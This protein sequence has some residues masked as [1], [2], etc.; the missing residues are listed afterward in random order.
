MQAQM[1]S[2][3]KLFSQFFY[4]A[5]QLADDLLL[6]LVCDGKGV[7]D[8]DYVPVH[9]NFMPNCTVNIE[10]DQSMGMPPHRAPELTDNGDSGDRGR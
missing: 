5:F 3:V 10:K 1:N 2:S 7:K 9:T 4:L 6:V 8:A